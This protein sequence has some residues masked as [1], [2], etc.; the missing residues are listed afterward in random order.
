M[1]IDG[2]DRNQIV[3]NDY[4]S[5]SIDSYQSGELRFQLPIIAPGVHTLKVKA[6]DVLNNSNEAS[7]Q[8]TVARKEKLQISAV[9]NFPNPFTVSTQFAFEHN[10]PN[11]NLLV[12]IQIFSSAGQKVRSIQRLLNTE[13]T[14]NVQISWKGD[15]D[16]G[17]KLAHG[18]YFYR[19]IVVADAQQTQSAGQ[20]LLY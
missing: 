5:N 15:T 14:R 10:Q 6:W 16:S 17:Q 2:D 4:Y 12:D 19:I 8:F 3:L 18:I 7:L 11:T 20:L 9:R 1:V 13:G